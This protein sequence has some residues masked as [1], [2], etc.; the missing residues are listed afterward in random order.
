M[1][2]PDLTFTVRPRTTSD[3]AKAIVQS[4]PPK[5]AYNVPPVLFVDK[6]EWDIFR[7][8]L[9]FLIRYALGWIWTMRVIV[10]DWVTST[11]GW[12]L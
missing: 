1:C 8:N 4:S 11:G 12:R 3:D 6:R 5:P 2:G 10:A 9:H 7:N